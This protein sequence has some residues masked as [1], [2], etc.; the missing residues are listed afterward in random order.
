MC[1]LR[2]VL[3]WSETLNTNLIVTSQR[4]DDQF[5]PSSACAVITALSPL[6]CAVFQP[7]AALTIPRNHKPPMQRAV[8]TRMQPS[9]ACGIRA[10]YRTDRTD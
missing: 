6:E 1:E 7:N 9:G 8:I 3:Y 10:K 4:S 5:K 2:W